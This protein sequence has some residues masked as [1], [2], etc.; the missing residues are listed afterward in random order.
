V[1][2]ERAWKSVLFNQ[3]HDILAGTSIEPACAE[4]LHGYGEAMA[5]AARATASALQ[6]LNWRIAIEQVDGSMPIVVWNPQSFPVRDCVELESAGSAL[7]GVRV[8]D[9]TGVEVPS[10]RVASVATVGEGR[11]RLA[12]VADVPALG[13]RV[14]RT[15]PA[16]EQRQAAEWEPA[17]IVETDRYRLTVEPE[18]GFVSSLWDHRAGVEVLAGPGG[19][20]V[21]VRDESD[22]WSHDVHQYRDEVGVFE[23]TRVMRVEAGPVKS[24]LRVESRFE[25]SRLAQDFTLYPA[26]D[27]IDVVVTLDWRERH[28]LLKLRWPVNCNFRRIT[29]EVPFGTI[30]RAGNGLEEPAQSWFDVS[31]VHRVSGDL[32]GLSILNDAKYA[33]DVLGREMSL[34]AVRS[35]VYAHHDPYQPDSWDALTFMDQGVQRFTYSLLPHL[36]GWEEAGTARQALALNQRL[37]PVVDT[38]HRGTLSPSGSLVEVTPASV[39]LTA[40]KAPEEGGDAVILRCLETAGAATCARVAMPGWQRTF[41]CELGAAELRTFRV[42]RDP[43]AP[44]VEVDLLERP[45]RPRP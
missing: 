26:L 22:T 29:Y 34:T 21:V 2:L 4:A 8:V 1:E 7:R 17:S 25:A 13:Y 31:G 28:R 38:A 42:P 32:Y 15:L 12:F 19:R 39:I 5:V 9:D 43:A 40:L 30:A 41:E 16:G 33:Y 36:G 3:F 37:L 11:G 6:S 10:Q 24:V 27:R 23:A 18:T 20:P 44:V 35:P 45:L 14:Y